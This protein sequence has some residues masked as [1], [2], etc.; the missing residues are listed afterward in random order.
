MT[1]TEY[2]RYRKRITRDGFTHEE[3][4]HCPVGMPLWAYRLTQEEGQPFESILRRELACKVSIARMAE[5]FGV[6]E[7]TLG[8]WTRKLIR[9]GGLRFG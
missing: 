3:A 5:S 6:K 7:C 1:D 2:S 8:H 4:L 9:E